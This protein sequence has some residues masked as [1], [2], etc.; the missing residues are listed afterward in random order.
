MGVVVQTPY[1][2]PGAGKTGRS[3]N[4]RVIGKELIKT[5]NNRGKFPVDYGQWLIKKLQYAKPRH[6]GN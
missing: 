5:G 6:V 1:L 3:G 4:Y 2:N